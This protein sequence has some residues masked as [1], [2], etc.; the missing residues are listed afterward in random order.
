MPATPCPSHDEL[1]AYSL[2]RLADVASDD[3]AAHLGSC[4]DCQA[5]LA[6]SDDLED[7]FVAQLR[8]PPP[9]DPYLA[10]PQ[11][12]VA[13]ARALAVLDRSSSDDRSSRSLYGKTLGEYQLMG[14]LGHGGMGT[15]YKALHTKLDRVVALK[16][17]A[18]DREH[19]QRAIARFE[20]EMK[21]IGKLDHRHIVRAYDARE[22]DG[23]PMLVMEYVDGLDL[24]E[25]VR[26]VGPLDSHQ[27]CEIVRQAA[28]GLQY[29]HEHGL[30]HRDVKPSNLMLT[31]QGDVK[32]LDL[33]LA[34]FPLE[35]PWDKEQGDTDR[36]VSAEITAT[37]QA[38]GTA[39]YMAPEQ[40]SN[41]R[42][43]DIRADIYGLGCTLYKLLSGR[44]PFSAPEHKGPLEKMVAHTSKPAP[45]IRQFC[46]DTPNG[47]VAVVDRMLAKSPDARY[48]IP[49]E[50]IEAL[51]PWCA[52]ADLTALLRRATEGEEE[53][54]PGEDRPATPV[55]AT[56]TTRKPRP[57]L[58]S[59]G[60]K[61]ITALLVLILIST[62]GFALAIIIHIKQGDQD[63]TVEPPP[64]STV[65]IGGD[66][67][68]TVELPG[69]AQSGTVPQIV[70][71]SPPVGAADVDPATTEITVTFDRDMDEGFSWTGGG[72][73]HPPLPDGKNA[74]WRDRRT[75]VL[76]V[77]LESGHYYRVG[78]QS[79]SYRNFRSAAGVPA[80]PSTVYFVTQGAS[81][82][83]KN[84][85]CKP[86]IV[87]MNPPNG[88][89]DVYPGLRELRVTF[90]V[91]MGEGFSWCGGG[92]HYPKTIDGPYWIEDRKTCVLP[93]ELK[94][95]WD[96]RL[97]LNSP[98]FN[99]FQTAAG[100]P[101]EPVEYVFTTRGVGANEG[102]ATDGAVERQPGVPRPEDR[103]KVISVS[104]APNASSVEPTTEIRIRFDRPMDPKRMAL[105]TRPINAGM[106]FRLH[107]SPRYV[108]TANEFVMPVILR[109]GA[110]Y[111]FGLESRLDFDH[112]V[113]EFRSLEGVAAT[114]YSW[115]FAT[116]D[117][118]ANPKTPKPR[119]VSVDPPSGSHTGM[120][121]TIR[122]RFDRPMDAEAFEPVCSI[123]DQGMQ[124]EHA[125]A[126]F[127]V[128]YDA[129][130]YTF[131]F[132]ASFP[133]ATSP[134]IDLRGFRGTEGGEAEP[135]TVNYEVGKSL[136][137]PEQEARIAAAGASPKLRE[138][139]DSV[140]R[141][142]LALKSLENTVRTVRTGP[143]RNAPLGWSHDLQVNHARFGFQGDRQF[144]ADISSM[145]EFSP[146]TSIPPNIFRLGSD[147]RECWFFASLRHAEERKGDVRLFFCPFQAMKEQTV[148]VADPFPQERFSSVENAIQQ[149]KLEYLG[150]TIHDGKIYHRVRSWAGEVFMNSAYAIQD[151]LIDAQSL[152]PAALQ[153]SF[154][155]CEFVY[156]HVNEPIST[157]MFQPRATPHIRREPYALE[158]GYQYFYL[159]ISDGSNGRMSGRWG[160]RGAKGDMNSGMN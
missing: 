152:L 93:V 30:T 23:T 14:E 140:R 112:K 60:H 121:V 104:P 129:S 2:G 116:R 94:P 139:L 79:D 103:P 55:R 88:A 156:T 158:E 53:P 102:A 76:P 90:N 72:P 148:I 63:T 32:I 130:S 100:I 160:Q 42:N 71:T 4:P 108:A 123:A 82:E 138:L 75:C 69:K 154:E 110:P 19:D 67:Q 120:I 124:F 65:R 41:S 150:Q 12:Q 73:E 49:A 51:A 119:V 46:P 11:C 135:A 144:Y 87:S 127:P 45:S 80:Q 5:E 143:G 85:V 64:G 141:N 29:V 137:L 105:H 78:I 21:A 157:E 27:A 107:G 6:S 57:L 66:G 17:L 40:V 18:L 81:E 133:R 59:W 134:R 38:M 77:K 13:V 39:D 95:G 145:M 159:R 70:R 10:E 131:T 61:W 33:G 109:A 128:E 97:G 101:L 142:R 83:V 84:R 96:Y 117:A 99:N 34:R 91:P 153:N 122:V 15:V 22:I 106:P 54:V 147:G 114:A 28:L 26:R 125:S 149:L 24:G 9:A 35:R 68:V 126:P 50:V 44:T 62:L 92:P 58:A 3:M 43:V 111:E 47:L 25:I 31:F 8:R 118:P 36:V 7:T 37:N 146:S 20:R 56:Q 155:R 52:G 132:Q 98:S 16:V 48:S 74:F 115:R 136:Y 89:K 86:Q 151:W 113:S 1:L